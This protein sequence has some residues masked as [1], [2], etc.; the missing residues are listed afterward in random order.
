MSILQE[1]GA[2]PLTPTKRAALAKLL[3][4]ERYEP[5]WTRTNRQMGDD[6]HRVYAIWAVN[7]HDREVLTTAHEQDLTNAEKSAKTLVEVKKKIAESLGV[8]PARKP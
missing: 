1:L 3:L 6:M 8:Q 2:P 7:A 5:L 4:D